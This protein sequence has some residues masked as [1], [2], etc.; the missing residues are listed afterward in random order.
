MAKVVSD[1]TEQARLSKLLSR[2]AGI[3]AATPLSAR[4]LR[5]KLGGR[6]GRKANGPLH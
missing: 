5:M 6:L 2:S 4:K 1:L 3:E